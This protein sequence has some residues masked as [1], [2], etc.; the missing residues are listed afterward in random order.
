MRYLPSIVATSICAAALF[1]CDASTDPG[2]GG[3]GA[4]VAT[5]T[6]RATSSSSATASSGSGLVGSTSSGSGSSTATSGGVCAVP[7]DT[8]DT[9]THAC[10]VAFDC[11][12]LVCTGID[13]LCPGF[14]PMGMV[15][16]TQF[17]SGCVGQCDTIGLANVA[18][19]L[20]VHDCAATIEHLK[21]MFPN[22][23][24][25]CM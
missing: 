15:D 1:G 22:F 12:D 25:V 4:A 10:E 2:A 3:G 17:R 23:S 7:N 16:K 5:S 11:G 21:A 8:T 9:C 20:D 13:Q 19:I 24:A 6:S 14:A 18:T